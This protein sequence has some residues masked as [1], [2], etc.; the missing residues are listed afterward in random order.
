MSNPF[1]TFLRDTRGAVTVDWTVLSAAAVAMSLATVGV[2]NGGIA[3]MVSRADGELREQQMSDNFIGF[4]S[5]HFEP[6]Y[7]HN[8]TTAEV[9]E[10]YFNAANEM[11]NQDIINALEL[12]ITAL[13]EGRLTTDDMAILMALASVAHQRNIIDDGVMNYYFGFDGSSGRISNAF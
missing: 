8:I 1:C 10:D 9:A 3:A 12:G 5:A 2:L 4:T 11:M 7:E 13:E 6:L